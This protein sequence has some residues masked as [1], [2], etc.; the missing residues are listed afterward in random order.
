MVPN[1]SEVL[2]NEPQGRR[3]GLFQFGLSLTFLCMFAYAWSVGDA[4]ET[5]WL[6]FMIVGTALSG[7]AESLPET[8]LQA[9]GVLRFTAGLVLLC[10]V[11][12]PFLGLG[13]II[14]G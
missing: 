5:R 8:Q 12:A 11:A 6:L 1:I 4:G 2:F 14:G 13:F 10:V 7:I 9:V 3:I